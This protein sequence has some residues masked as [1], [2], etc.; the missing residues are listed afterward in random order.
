MFSSYKMPNSQSWALATKQHVKSCLS[1]QKQHDNVC[2]Q[3]ALSAL[4]CESAMR[5]S[6]LL[7][8]GVT[9]EGSQARFLGPQAVGGVGRQQRVPATHK[10]SRYKPTTTTTKEEKKPTC[11]FVNNQR[12]GGTAPRHP[13]L[14][15]KTL[16]ESIIWDSA[17]T[18]VVSRPF[19]QFYY[20]SGKL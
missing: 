8:G 11:A 2:W 19:L 13:K 20:S 7:H 3:R 9:Q 16:Q 6:L 1:H 12:G 18:L 15:R 14:R 17:K 5:K 10:V 4:S